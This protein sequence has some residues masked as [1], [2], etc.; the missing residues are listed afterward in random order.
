MKPF[1]LTPATRDDLIEIWT[2][3]ANDSVDRADQ[4]IAD[5]YDAFGRLAQSPGIGHYRDDLADR[6]HRFWVVYSYIVVYRWKAAPLQIIAV[7]HGSRHLRA[8]LPERTEE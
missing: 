5:L 2:Y 8:L 4:V 1:V 6:R 3:I 7:F